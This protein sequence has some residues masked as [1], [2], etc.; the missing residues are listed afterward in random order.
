MTEKIDFVVTY[1]DSTDEDWIKQKAQYSGESIEKALNSEARFRNMDN[2]QY[3]FRA[4][5]KYAG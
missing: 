5:E 4:V 3:W 1:L 2:F